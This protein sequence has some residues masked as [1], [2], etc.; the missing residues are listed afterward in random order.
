MHE[1]ETYPEAPSPILERDN[2]L[3]EIDRRFREGHRTVAVTGEPGSGKTTI[4]AQFCRA[5]QEAVFAYFQ[6]DDH[7]SSDPHVF[8]TDVCAQLASFLSLRRPASR[9][10]DGLRKD[11]RELVWQLYRRV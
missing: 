6:G 4:L 2:L 10:Y 7:W 3:A 1:S 5:S 9:S 8:L 11:F